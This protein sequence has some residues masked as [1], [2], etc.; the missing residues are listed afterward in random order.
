MV[1]RRWIS[2][3]AIIG[4]LLHAGFFARQSVIA[5]S[6]VLG[7]A[8]PTGFYGLIC[9]ADVDP[10]ASPAAD[11][12]AKE[13][14]NQQHRHCPLCLGVLG[15]VAVL[16]SALCYHAALYPAALDVPV[17]HETLTSAAHGF[18]PPGRAPP[19]LS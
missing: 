18:W 10:A 15:A 6:A 4:V 5:L 14:P 19:V 9:H 2:V 16:P 13:S 7:N 17:T 3:V 11:S 12:P 8:N 1:R